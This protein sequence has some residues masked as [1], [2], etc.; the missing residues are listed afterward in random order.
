MIGEGCKICDGGKL[1]MVEQ[2]ELSNYYISSSPKFSN[3]SI[4]SQ[5]FDV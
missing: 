2:E 3:S 1:A 5:L 4:D